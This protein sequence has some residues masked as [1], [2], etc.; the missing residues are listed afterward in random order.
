[1]LPFPA[2]L[3]IV[4]WQSSTRGAITSD[5]ARSLQRRRACRTDIL[6]TPRRGPPPFA[7]CRSWPPPRCSAAVVF[8]TRQRL[9]LSRH[10]RIGRRKNRTLAR[11]A[12][13]AGAQS[14]PFDEPGARYHREHAGGSFGSRHPGQRGTAAPAAAA[15]PKLTAGSAIDL[16]FR[17]G[18]PSASDHPRL[19]GALCRG[20]CRARLFRSAPR[21]SAG[22]LY[23]RHPPIGLRRAA[24]LHLQPGAP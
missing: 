3:K 12:A 6:R 5:H 15:D 19:S 10:L 23:R 18:R 8:R 16:D 24:L 7:C 4:Y 13:R 9:E 1:M 11:R 20:F 17:P 14:V 2:T 21:R 22:R